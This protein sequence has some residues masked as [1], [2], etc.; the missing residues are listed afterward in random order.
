MATVVTN[1]NIDALM[2][3]SRGNLD[4]LEE[5][6]QD[7]KKSLSREADVCQEKAREENQD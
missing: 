3:L 7:W 1:T 6:A 2:K 5:L 4:V